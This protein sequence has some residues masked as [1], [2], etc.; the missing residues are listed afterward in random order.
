M[1]TGDMTLMVEALPP[2]AAQR[3]LSLSELVFLQESLL[4]ILDLFHIF[5]FDKSSFKSKNTLKRW[6]VL[7]SYSTPLKFMKYKI[8][9]FFSAWTNDDVPKSP[10]PS[11][12]DNPRALLGGSAYRWLLLQRQTLHPEIFLSLI[13]SVL[14]SKKG[15]PRPTE[16]DLRDAEEAAFATMTTP[17]PQKSNFWLR[18]WKTEG[19][20]RLDS[21]VSIETVKEQLKRTVHEMFTGFEVGDSLRRPKPFFPSTSSDYVSSRSKG[22]A[23]ASLKESGLLPEDGMGCGIKFGSEGS[24]VVLDESLLDTRFQEFWEKLAVAQKSELPLVSPV[25]L[26]EPLKVRVISKGPAQLYTYLKP[27]QKLMWKRMQQFRC[28]ELTG[29]PVTA[30]YVQSVMG[31]KLTGLQRF[32]SVDYSAAT[33]NLHMWVSECI[34]NAICDE[35]KIE[36]FRE[37]FLRSLTGHIYTHNG[38]QSPQRRGQLMGSVTSFPVLCIANAAICRWAIEL[39]HDRQ[40]KLNDCPMAINGDDGLLKVTPV[41]RN[42]WERISSFCGLEPSIGKVYFSKTILNINSTTFLYAPDGFTDIDLYEKGRSF[43]IRQHFEHIKYVNLG[44]MRGMGRSVST[45]KQ[46]E[47][48]DRLRSI[49]TEDSIGARARDLINTCPEGYR[50]IVMQKYIYHN[51]ETLVST[52]LP[53]F[54]PESAGGLGLPEV[55]K[56][57]LDDKHL[58]LLRVQMEQN[59]RPP[60]RPTFPKWATWKAAQS[61]LKANHVNRD[62]GVKVR[63]QA[64]AYDFWYEEVCHSDSRL[65]EKDLTAKF[66]TDLLFTAPL[67]RLMNEPVNEN[68]ATF[69]SEKRIADGYVNKLRR[70]WSDLYKTEVYPEPLSDSKEFQPKFSL[71]SDTPN[72]TTYSLLN[73]PSKEFEIRRH[74]RTALHEGEQN[75]DLD[76]CSEGICRTFYCA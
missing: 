5:G 69:I 70:F 26:A 11:Q 13:T 48:Q 23:V 14:Y 64:R 43:T 41:G 22:G 75:D 7:A 37:P 53:W 38:K 1:S 20:T 68:S 47:K 2:L 57:C 67:N 40:F 21:L 63:N 60:G 62:E 51:H 10:F 36:E 3:T 46:T 24:R 42:F 49:G 59:I 44:L 17:M 33:D 72:Y 18:D 27:L 55:G 12:Y 16:K 50:E 52:R 71:V 66:C 9:A 54:V 35:L 74:S 56:Y 15:M 8:A 32:L 29:K 58:R 28:F 61:E 73:Q 39:D 31:K 6:A 65:S 76:D 4:L 19:E 25:A 30:R 45:D 34:A